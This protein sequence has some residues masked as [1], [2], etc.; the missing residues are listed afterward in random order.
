M[1]WDYLFFGNKKS[2]VGFTILQLMAIRECIERCYEEKLFRS[3]MLE[4]NA[5]EVLEKLK[6]IL[7]NKGRIEPKYK[8]QKS[9]LLKQSAKKP[10]AK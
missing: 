1:A 7:K 4:N 3:Y 8:A 5:Y 6:P 10:R 2:K 9:T